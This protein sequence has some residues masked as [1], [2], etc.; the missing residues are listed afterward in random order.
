[1]SIH[2]EINFENAIA[3]IL[4]TTVG[5]MPRAMLADTSERGLCFLTM[6]LTL[7]M[8]L[9][10]ERQTAMIFAAVTGKI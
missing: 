4:R 5:S 2:T 10:Q 7:H 6:C 1:M 3:N 8:E 9:L